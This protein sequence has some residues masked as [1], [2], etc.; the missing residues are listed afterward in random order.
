MAPGLVGWRGLTARHPEEEEI[1]MAN[2]VMTRS[3][4]RSLAIVATVLA[5]VTAACGSATTSPSA[6]AASD[7][8]A[9][10]APGSAA[11]GGSP[12]A[13]A[14]YSGPPATIEYAIWGDPAEIDS[15]TKL[16]ESFDA[17]N[18]TIDVKVTV[19]DWDAYWD[20]LQTGLPAAR[21]PTCSR[22]MARSSPTTRPAT[23][24]WTSSRSSTRDGYDLGQLADQGVGVFTTVGGRPVRPAARPQR[25]RALLQQGDVRRGRHPVPRRHLGLGQARRGRASS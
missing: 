17:A 25:H 5:L 8:P 3:T 11:P 6:P 7:A 20:K 19:A 12:A 21:R 2:R 18:P 4:H 24:C 16:V 23:C 22:W 1:P 9:S 10:V 14:G 13:S 15:Q